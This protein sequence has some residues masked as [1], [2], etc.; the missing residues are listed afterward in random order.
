MESLDPVGGPWVSTTEAAAV[1]G[2]ATRTVRRM[3]AD[4]RL[5]GRGE[6]RARVATESVYVRLRLREPDRPPPR[7]MT[8]DSPDESSWA[9]TTLPGTGGGGR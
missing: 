2:V 3:V 8:W 4:G 5:E 6:G 1:L 7:V 9:A